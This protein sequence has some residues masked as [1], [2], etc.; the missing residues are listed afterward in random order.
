MEGATSSI[1]NAMDAQCFS[2]KVESANDMYGMD[3]ILTINEV[4][5]QVGEQLGPRTWPKRAHV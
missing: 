1:E 4:R 2:L 5:A 3:F